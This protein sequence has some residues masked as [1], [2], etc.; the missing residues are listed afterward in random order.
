[1]WLARPISPQHQDYINPTYPYG[2]FGDGTFYLHRGVDFD[3]NPV[4]TPLYAVANGTIIVAGKD[5]KEVYGFEPNFY[6]RL[7]VIELARQ[8]QS[9]PVYALYGHVS[10]IDVKV[11]DA[12]REGQLIGAVGEEGT[13]AVGPH[14]HFEVRVDENDYDHTRNPALWLKPPEGT[15]TVV[16]RLLNAR[17]EPI[18][19]TV[20]IFRR[21]SKPD[22]HYRDTTTY[23]ANRPIN[24]DDDWSENF[25]MAELEAGR[26]LVSAFAGGRFYSAEVEVVAGRTT[27]IILK[28]N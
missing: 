24:P 16:G 1:L 15:G 8:W 12:V 6:G 7:M 10:R 27:F 21:A 28:P 3:N 19:R 2:S 13:A 26:M 11:G 18:P 14:L 9:R 22:V 4:G 20:V 17:G 25:V 23:P 5:D